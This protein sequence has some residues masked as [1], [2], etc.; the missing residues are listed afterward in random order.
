MAAGPAGLPP[1]KVAWDDFAKVG[2]AI[3]VLATAMSALAV[4]GARARRVRRDLLGALADHARR[5]RARLALRPRGARGPGRADAAR[6]GGAR[7]RRR[8]RRRTAVGVRACG[9]R[10]RR[11]DAGVRLARRRNAG[12]ARAAR[13]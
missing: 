4:T 8:S 5:R 9:R 2:A 12:R 11:R 10:D 1:A 7:A 3:A 6:A 13:V